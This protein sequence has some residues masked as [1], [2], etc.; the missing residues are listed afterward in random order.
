MKKFLQKIFGLDK[1]RPDFKKGRFIIT[2]SL[3]L[4]FIVV[5]IYIMIRGCEDKGKQKKATMTSEVCIIRQ[6]PCKSL[7]F[8][9]V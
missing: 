2:T 3:L 6:R 8:K 4:L 9:C 7:Q 5:T 1:E